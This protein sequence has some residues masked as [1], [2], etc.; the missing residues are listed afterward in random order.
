[1]NQIEEYRRGT[2]LADDVARRAVIRPSAA[3]TVGGKKFTENHQ[4]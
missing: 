3:G 4:G 2:L 1:M